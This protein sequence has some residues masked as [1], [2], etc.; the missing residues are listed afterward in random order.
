MKRV[1]H[2]EIMEFIYDSKEQRETH[3]NIMKS[4]GWEAGDRLKRLHPNVSIW[5]ATN[6]D[7]EWFAEFWKCHV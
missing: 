4:N 1:K 2:N 6:E 5:G 7:Y 3:I